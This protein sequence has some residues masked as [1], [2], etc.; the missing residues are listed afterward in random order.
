MMVTQD[1]SRLRIDAQYVDDYL[2]LTNFLKIHNPPQGLPV[3]LIFVFHSQTNENFRIF[4]NPPRSKRRENYGVFATR[5]PRRPNPLGVSHV[6]L[7]DR[8]YCENGDLLLT[9]SGVDLLNQT[10]IL[11]LFPISSNLFQ[12]QDATGGWA[13][14]SIQQ[15]KVHWSVDLSL[16]PDLPVQHL[17]ELLSWDP[18]PTAVK[19]RFPVQTLG[20]SRQE[21]GIRLLGFEVKFRFQDLEIEVFSLSL[22]SQFTR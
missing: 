16:F 19:Q 15:Y 5:S 14:A 17:E 20:S 13:S 4:V 2:Y 8:I 7:L 3:G 11:D 1:Y 22:A 12:R 21:F 10:P 6:R 9:F 18:R